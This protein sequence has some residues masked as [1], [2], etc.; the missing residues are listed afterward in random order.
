MKQVKSIDEFLNDIECI[1]RS[2][3][4]CYVHYSIRVH[5]VL[6]DR[7]INCICPLNKCSNIKEALVYYFRFLHK[8]EYRLISIE[9]DGY[10]AEELYNLTLA[11]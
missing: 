2:N 9:Y 10:T 3:I 6:R 7:Y 4:L 8:R 5:D 1:T 11:A